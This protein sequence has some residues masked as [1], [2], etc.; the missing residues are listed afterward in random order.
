MNSTLLIALYENNAAANQVVLETAA[1]LAPEDLIKE[2]SPSHHNVLRLLSHMAYVESNFLHACQGTPFV[3]ARLSG[4]DDLRQ[5]WQTVTAQ[6]LAY[7]PTLDET[8]L[9]EELPVPIS[10]ALFHFPRWQMLT[11]ALLHS[12]HHRG[13]LSVVL[14]GLGQPLP[15][16][17][18]IIRFTEQSGQVWPWKSR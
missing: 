5:F 3:F 11:Q 14:T 17:D 9:Q 16:L 1:H 18:I 13:E 10:K 12:A 4:L 15:D 7:L 6:L 2:A 8:A